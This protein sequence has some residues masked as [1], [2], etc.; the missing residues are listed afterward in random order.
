MELLE[1]VTSVKTY[2]SG[3][4]RQ[5]DRDTKSAGERWAEILKNV[6]HHNVPF[7]NVAIICRFSMCLPGTNASVEHKFSL[8][9]NTWTNERIFLGLDTFKRMSLF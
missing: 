1:E 5:W 6:K 3:K 9:T 2:R 8:M 4:I 7:Q